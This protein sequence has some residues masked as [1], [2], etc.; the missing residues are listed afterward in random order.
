MMVTAHTGGSR[1]PICRVRT[2]KDLVARESVSTKCAGKTVN[3]AIP[4]KHGDYIWAGYN[5]TCVRDPKTKEYC[6]GK[7]IP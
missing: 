3:G 4:T 1:T 6:N 2:M 5:E 7:Y